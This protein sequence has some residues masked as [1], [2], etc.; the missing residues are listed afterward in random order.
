MF[1]FCCEVLLVKF[2]ALILMLCCLEIFFLCFCFT[3]FFPFFLSSLL[4]FVNCYVLSRQVQI[5]YDV[6]EGIHTKWGQRI[7]VYPVADST[8]C[9]MQGKALQS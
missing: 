6:N 4:L 5:F 3:F 8:H 9:Y 7:L 2:N 1:Y